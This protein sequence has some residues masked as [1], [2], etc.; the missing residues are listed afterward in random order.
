MALTKQHQSSKPDP[1]DCPKCGAFFNSPLR[2]ETHSWY[3]GT[4][5]EFFRC[6][7]CRTEYEAS[8][9]T[10]ADETEPPAP[11]EETTLF[12]STRN[13]LGQ[14]ANWLGDKFR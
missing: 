7:V 3:P 9:Q 8:R 5:T 11:A 6:E 10:A 13:R 1:R 4:V 12:N 14:I 2:S